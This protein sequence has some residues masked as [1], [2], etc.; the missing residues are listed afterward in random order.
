MPRSVSAR[1]IVDQHVSAT[2]ARLP[3]QPAV[4]EARANRVDS[5]SWSQL[6]DSTARLAAVFK[7]ALRPGSRPLVAVDARNSI[8]SVTAVVALLRA[9]IPFVPMNPHSPAL[10][11]ERLL[12]NAWEGYGGPVFRLR[13]TGE[14]LET[15]EPATAVVEPPPAPAAPR[16]HYILLG[17]G[18]TGLPKLVSGW[19]DDGP[20]GPMG[21]Y[22]LLLS[23][24]GWQVDLRQLIV[25]PL[26][27]S[28]PFS[29]LMAGILD[30]HTII[31]QG[32]FTAERT[33][34][35]I[36]EQ[37]VEWM[38]LT[39]S[40]MRLLKSH[41]TP[42][43]ST[44]AHVRGVLHT[45][46][47]C[48]AVTKQEWIALLGGD[49]IFETYSAT[50]QIGTTLASGEDWVTRPGTVGKGF[51]T[52]IRI[53]DEQGRPLPAGRTGIVYMRRG[54]GATAS[55]NR[56]SSVGHLPNGFLTVGDRGRLDEDGYL[57]LSGRR[58]D[59]MQVGGS[60]VYAS[61]IEQTILE[62]P[63]VKDVMVTGEEHPTLGSTPRARV[64]AEPGRVLAPAEI[65]R[66]CRLRLSAYKVPHI[67][68]IVDSLPR[69]AAGKMERWRI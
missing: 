26:Y 69:S 23:R 7:G 10:E 42:D 60:N 44:L 5:L 36:R 25:G 45:A 52:Q 17:G 4:I 33:W 8:D 1:E 29:N 20:M 39:P 34:E 13:S 30:S 3:H 37:R 24:A 9:G 55:A 49:R 43:P 58:S 50:E 12:L 53:M 2:A 51:L 19:L 31:L 68:D 61:E 41:G 54:R 66:H 40:H 32:V 35:V 56:P 15:W 47:P 57:Y 6:A 63:G 11:R 18:T 48:D 38:Q 21:G 67:I 62:L 14:G 46:A 16:P 64:V 59:A 22:R 28:A 27:H 65:R